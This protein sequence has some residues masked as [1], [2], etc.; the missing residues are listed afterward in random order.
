MI[1]ALVDFAAIQDDDLT[2]RRL[3]ISN[4]DF[5]GMEPSLLSQERRVGLYHE[6]HCIFSAC[7]GDRES[8]GKTTKLLSSVLRMSAF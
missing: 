4:L 1:L 3:F 5:R 8:A 2:I 6:L 7:C